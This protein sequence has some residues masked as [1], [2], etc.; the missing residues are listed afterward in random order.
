MDFLNS[1]AFMFQKII[2][3]YVF[4]IIP[5]WQPPQDSRQTSINVLSPLP[6]FAAPTEN[7]LLFRLA[8]V[9]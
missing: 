1:I 7:L 5:G 9:Q 3:Q 4:E 2:L 8:P 6:G